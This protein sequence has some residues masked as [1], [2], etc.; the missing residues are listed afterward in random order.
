MKTVGHIEL[1]GSLGFDVSFIR[2]IPTPTG[3]KI[4]FVT[5]RK[6]GFGEAATASQSEAFDLSAGELDLNDQNKKKSTGI[7][8]PAAKLII[9][10]EGE[11]Q[12]EEAQNPWKLASFTDFKGTPGV[13]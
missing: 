13:N 8:Y 9:N 3:R 5:N 7:L 11:L 4:R 2:L 1:T 10:K 12:I 6:I